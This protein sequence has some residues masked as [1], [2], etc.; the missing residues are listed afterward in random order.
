MSIREIRSCAVCHPSLRS[1]GSRVER[2]CAPATV[3]LEQGEG[4][5]VLSRRMPLTTVR[6]THTQSVTQLRKEHII[7]RGLDTATQIEGRYATP[8]LP[9]R[10]SQD[11]LTTSLLPKPQKDKPGCL[12]PL[13]GELNRISVEL[14][15]VAICNPRIALRISCPATPH[16]CATPLHMSEGGK[17]A[18]PAPLSVAEVKPSSSTISLLSIT[19]PKSSVKFESN[20]HPDDPTSVRSYGTTDCPPRIH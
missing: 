2:H 7:L 10:T 20:A 3:Q 11:R 8:S 5:L 13:E 12:K 18:C 14:S 17:P 15:N 4:S 9:I 1:A 16:H 19:S 6:A